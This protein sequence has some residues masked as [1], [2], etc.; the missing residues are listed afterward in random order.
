M[1]N[2]FVKFIKFVVAI[3][4]GILIVIFIY[5]FVTGDESKIRDLFKKNITVQMELEEFEK[6]CTDK[7]GQIITYAENGNY[8]QNDFPVIRY[9]CST[10]SDI[11]FLG[12][13]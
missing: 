1:N 5:P 10:K 6:M 3:L 8:S 13:A 11:Y 4:V 2:Q 9:K 12:D 7:S